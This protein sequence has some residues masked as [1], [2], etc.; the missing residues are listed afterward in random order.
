MKEKHIRGL[1]AAIVAGLGALIAAG[2]NQPESAWETVQ[3]SAGI[4]TAAITAWM[5]FLS[6]HSGLN[7]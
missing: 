6:K 3:L 7:P 1:G 2:T 4:A 5:S